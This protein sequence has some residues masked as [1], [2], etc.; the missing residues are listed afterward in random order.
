M[1]VVPEVIQY[2]YEYN[3]MATV[4]RYCAV[5]MLLVLYHHYIYEKPV[6]IPY[7]YDLIFKSPRTVQSSV[8]VQQHRQSSINQTASP[9]GRVQRWLTKGGPGRLGSN[10][11]VRGHQ[12]SGI[13]IDSGLQAASLL[14][15]LRK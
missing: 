6:L 5:L 7:A 1:L 12:G 2:E 15:R 4:L 9:P 13:S 8:P 10:S 3:K 14:A 11:C